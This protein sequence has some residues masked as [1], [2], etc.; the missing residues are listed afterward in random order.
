VWN[1]VEFFPPPKA[2][3]RVMVVKSDS[4]FEGDLP[5]VWAVPVEAVAQLV[6]PIPPEG[7]DR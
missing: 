5:L 3:G 4:E 7:T 2:V 6:R 1:K